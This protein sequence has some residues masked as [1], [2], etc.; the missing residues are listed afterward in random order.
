MG[1]HG[2]QVAR[3][4]DGEPGHDHDA[5]AEDEPHPAAP[6]AEPGLGGDVDVERVDRS[7]DEDHRPDQGVADGHERDPLVAAGELG[8]E[9]Q[10]L[11]PGGVL[12]ALEHAVG[13]DLVGAAVQELVQ[14]VLMAL[15]QQRHADVAGDRQDDRDEGQDLAGDEV[16]QVQ[17][18]QRVRRGTQAGEVDRVEG[19]RLAQLVLAGQPLADEL[20]LDHD[21]EGAEAQADDHRGPGAG[22][23]PALPVQ[24][25]DDRRARAAD[26]DGAGQGQEHRDV[27]AGLVVVAEGQG[28]D[29]DAEDGAL[30]QEQVRAGGQGLLAEGQ[31]HVLDEDRPPRVQVGVVGADEGAQHGRGEQAEQADR[32]QLGGGERGA[33]LGHQGVGSQAVQAGLD[34][35]GRLGVGRVVHQGADRQRQHDRDQHQHPEAPAVQDVRHARLVGVL[36]GRVVALVA[37]PGAHPVEQDDDADQPVEDVEVNLDIVHGKFDEL[38]RRFT[39]D[40]L[41][42]D[43]TPNPVSLE[44]VPGIGGLDR[45]VGGV[46]DNVQTRSENVFDDTQD[47]LNMYTLSG[48]WNMNSNLTLEATAG[49]SKAEQ[50]AD[51]FRIL[52][53]FYGRAELGET[54]YEGTVVPTFSSLDYD[55]TDA[56]AYGFN[57]L[58]YLMSDIEDEEKNLKFDVTYNVDWG[59]F[60]ALKAGV[61]YAE[62][63]FSRVAYDERINPNQDNPAPAFEDVASLNYGLFGGGTPDGIPSDWLI[64]QRD[65]FEAAQ[66][67]VANDFVP[68]ISYPSTYRVKEDTLAGYAQ[69]SV[70]TPVGDGMYLTGN[71]GVRVVKTDQ[72]STGYVLTDSGVGTIGE[73]SDYTDVLPSINLSLDVTE[74][75]II[76]LAA[77]K[78]MTRATLSQLSP[79]ISS[80]D[81]ATQSASQGNPNLDPFRVKQIDLG[82]EYYFAEDALVSFTGFFKDIESF[83][84][85]TTESRVLNF[86]GPLYRDDGTDISNEAFNVSL[87]VNGK[88]A[89]IRGLEFIYQQPLTFLPIEGFGVIVNYTYAKTDGVTHTYYGESFETPFAG[90]SENSYNLT[91]YYENDEFSVRLAYAWR[92]EFVT[93]AAGDSQSTLLQDAYGQLDL[94]TSYSL[95]DSID[96]SLDVLN[97]TDETFSQYG[98]T[99]D[100]SVGVYGYGRTIVA[101]VQ[102]AF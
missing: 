49:Y 25:A 42:F 11:Q 37:L 64:V 46:F 33:R 92:D 2:A 3:S 47:E 73:E 53:D 27:L 4:A 9:A 36:G 68:A 41:Y 18:E 78:A 20:L 12:L 79:G 14:V 88:G 59:I 58:R 61:R 69:L 6:P 45:V 54:S 89:K 76:R 21:A 94:S 71:L 102:I 97:V 1:E 24:T 101:G 85:T 60:S 86:G 8:V 17:P 75:V 32:E 40:T 95:T 51:N 62:H 66:T 52:Y 15:A 26:E 63:E 82:V 50:L 48:K 77:S 57:Q 10:L 5:Q 90:A 55:F 87:P 93:N 29:R 96:V 38:N 99:K 98:L 65:D 72:T 70:D 83:I 13:L 100:R 7:G 35:R 84:T 56:S 80:Y 30:Q 91:G 22:G 34:D 31:H 28:E 23:R 81:I 44:T 19:D 74:D 16:V 39:I 67:M 43:G